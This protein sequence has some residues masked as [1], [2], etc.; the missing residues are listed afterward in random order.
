MR[1]RESFRSPPCGLAKTFGVHFQPAPGCPVADHRFFKGWVLKPACAAK[2]QPRR[3]TDAATTRQAPVTRQERVKTFP[4]FAS[5]QTPAAIPAAAQRVARPV[6][7]RGNGF[8]IS[9]Y[10]PAVVY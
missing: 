9:K 10:E 3:I 2:A 1:T 6:P 8:G 7:L 4:D 5:S